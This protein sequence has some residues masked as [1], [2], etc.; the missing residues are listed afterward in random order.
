MNN[1]Q[2]S[3]KSKAEWAN[4]EGH[5][6]ALSNPTGEII[7]HYPPNIVVG[8][9]TTREEHYW[10]YDDDE[11]IRLEMVLVSGEYCYSAPTGLFNLA[12][13]T[14]RRKTNIHYMNESYKTYR[15]KLKAKRA[16]ETEETKDTSETS[17][18]EI[19]EDYW[20]NNKMVGPL[21]IRVKLDFKQQDKDVKIWYSISSKSG[22]NDNINVVLPLSERKVHLSA[23]HRRLSESLIIKDPSKGFMFK[24]KDDILVNMRVTV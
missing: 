6:L 21:L 23:G 24:D 5:W 2:A 17:E 10:T 14:K 9:L 19:D 12:V 3:L 8:K 13:P 1:L 7:Q 16:D 15:N 11:I 22:N 4:M 18:E 20:D